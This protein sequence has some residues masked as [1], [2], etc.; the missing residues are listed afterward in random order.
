MNL[1]TF[2]KM[3][4]EKGWYLLRDFRKYD[5]QKIQLVVLNMLKNLKM[6]RPE[7][8]YN[9]TIKNADS[10]YHGGFSHKMDKLCLELQLGKYTN[11]IDLEFPKLINDNTFMLNGSVYVPILFLERAP[12][13]R[14]GSKA[15]K[16]NKILLNIPTQP[17]IFDWN[18][19]TVKLNKKQAIDLSVFFKALFYDEAY[20]ELMQDLTAEFGKPVAGNRELT[21]SECKQKVLEALGVTGDERFKHLNIDEFFD[22]Y[23]LLDYIKEIF[24]DYYGQS[25]FKNIVRVVYEYYQKDIEINMADIRNRRIVMTEYL[26][27][28]LF[29]WYNK[30]LYNFIDSEF[31]E[32][33]IPSLNG[34]CIISEGFR[35]RMHGEQLFNITLPYITPIVHKISQAI[36]IISG[37]VPKKW[38]SNHPSAM[39]VLCPISVSAQ[40]MGQN[41]VATLATEINFYGRIK[42]KTMENPG[43]IVPL[44]KII[45]TGQSMGEK[46][47]KRG[48]YLI[49]TETGEV[50]EKIPEIEQIDK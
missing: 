36:V 48:D 14:V 27:H 10:L 19:K 7:F 34:N 33:V 35:D 16:K 4:P 41:L 8:N 26:I 30:F 21:W 11:K 23:V 2:D 25:D 12:I 18:T 13:D 45:P 42:S 5:Y 24:H 32:Y 49:D 46:V 9:V 15:E 39:G 17:I 44:V 37:K 28:P 31:K 29:E 38:T 3:E 22:K 1:I 47:V 20:R 50:K 6:I 40:D 43:T